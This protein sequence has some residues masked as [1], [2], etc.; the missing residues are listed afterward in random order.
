MNPLNVFEKWTEDIET[1]LKNIS[2][3]AGLMASHH[4]TRYEELTQKLMWYKIPS[5]VLS[6]INSV[7][8]I[9]LTSYIEQ[10]AVSTITCLISLLVGCIGSIELYLSIQRRSDA[11]LL[12]YKQFY[13]LALK[14]NAMLKLDAERRQGDGDTFLTHCLG[15]YS[16]FFESSQ[17][18][19]LGEMDELVKL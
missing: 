18:N 9:G 16:A 3:N 17:V 10:K 8:A 13:A 15:E 6:S 7:F 2:H 5:I 12:S 14:I 11:E 1:V 19:G 4:K